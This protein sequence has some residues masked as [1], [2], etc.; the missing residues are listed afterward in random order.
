[1]KKYENLPRNF[2]NEQWL[3]VLAE[4]NDRII[5]LL[6]KLVGEDKSS[7]K[8]PAKSEDKAEEKA[9][10]KAEAKSEEITE[11]KTSGRSAAARPSTARSSSAEKKS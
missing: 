3:G 8:A 5:D 2:A 7:A 6:E 11:P 9:P 4:Q 10:A 1:M